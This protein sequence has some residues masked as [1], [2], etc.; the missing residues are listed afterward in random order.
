MPAHLSIIQHL[1]FHLLKLG[2]KNKIALAHSRGVESKGGER[3]RCALRHRHSLFFFLAEKT[4]LL[5]LQLLNWEEGDRC[6]WM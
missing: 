1:L 6:F 3:R 5:E 4:M 2:E